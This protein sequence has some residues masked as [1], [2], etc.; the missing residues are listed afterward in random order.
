MT[1]HQ[2]GLGSA[3][4]GPV[5]T[6][7]AQQGDQRLLCRRVGQSDLGAVREVR[8][9]LRELLAATPQAGATDVAELLTS[10]L[11]TNA[12]VHTGHGAVVTVAVGEAGL[13]VEVRDFTPALPT[14]YAPSS[15]DGTHGRG[16][17]LVQALAD[18]WGVSEHDRGKVVWFELGDGVAR[19]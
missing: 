1:R 10:E 2:A 19:Y 6:P 16:L 8:H 5:R 18:A 11:L 4:S 3:R 13:R 15:D 12:L 14:P 7:D 9:A 17:L